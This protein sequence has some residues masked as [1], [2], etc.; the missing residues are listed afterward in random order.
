[1]KINRSLCVLYFLVV[2]NAA[3]AVPITNL[4][5]SDTTVQVGEQFELDVWILNDVVG[6]ELL[7]FGFDLLPVSPLLSY[8]GYTLPIDFV[9]VSFGAQNVAG[10]AFP[11]IIGPNMLLATLMFQAV[12][13]GVANIEVEGL[14]D[15][16][17]FGLFYE[18]SGFDISGQTA[19]TIES[20]PVI[21]PTPNAW[22]ISLIAFAAWLSSRKSQ[23]IG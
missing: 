6:E 18:N 19:I 3:M 15:G 4:V 20:A 12:D 11:G 2:S 21:M 14:F 5:L 13:V 16:A 22:L 17:F 8:S 10:L 23:S 9:D 1:M 7:S